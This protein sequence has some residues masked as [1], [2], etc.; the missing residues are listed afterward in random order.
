MATFDGKELDI[1]HYPA[2]VLRQRAREV[3][4]PGEELRPLVERMVEVM[5][6]EGGIGLAAPQVGVS[7]RVIVVSLTA[8]PEDAVA[9]VNPE[10]SD[11]DGVEEM[12]EGCLS[13]P[14]VRAR[15]RRSARCW[16][17][18]LDL[19]GKVVERELE[20]ME[21]RVF[22]HE[23]DHL[24]GVLFI[25]RLGSVAKLAVRRKLRQ[26]EAAER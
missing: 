23:V 6:E 20:E 7:L 15:V 4:R 21:A 22:Q 9:Y 24:N 13:L 16:L 5:M 3:D 17:R 10:L 1:V 26:L 8:K 12:E 18:A 25:D 2:E 11:F 14:G 19:E